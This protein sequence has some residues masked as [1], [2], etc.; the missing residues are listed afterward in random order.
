MIS[1][2]ILRLVQ[3]HVFGAISFRKAKDPD[4]S[5]G[6]ISQELKLLY[7]TRVRFIRKV[8]LRSTILSNFQGRTAHLLWFSISIIWINVNGAHFPPDAD[9]STSVWDAEANTQLPTLTTTNQLYK[10]G[11]TQI[12]LDRIINH[13]KN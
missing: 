2:K 8:K 9:S 5:F 4:S 13:T 3:V 1:G 10:L 6:S 11:K 7:V 12:K